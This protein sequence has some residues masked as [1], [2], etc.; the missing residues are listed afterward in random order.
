MEKLASI[1]F[2]C[3][4][5]EETVR[6]LDSNIEYGLS[7][8]KVSTATA[9]YG[10][11]TSELEDNATFLDQIKSQFEDHTVRLLLAAATIS[12]IANLFSKTPF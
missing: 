2:H 12:F 1:D 8:E 11:V 10:K 9:R 7:D 4:T 5:V 6:I 3:K